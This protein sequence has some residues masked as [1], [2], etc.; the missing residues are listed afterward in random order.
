MGRHGGRAIAYIAYIHAITQIEFNR[1]FHA[2]VQSLFTSYLSNLSNPIL[3]LEP[4]S[5]YVLSGEARYDWSH[6]IAAVTEEE[7]EGEI[8]ERGKRISITFRHLNHPPSHGQKTKRVLPR[9]TA[10][11]SVD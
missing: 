8:I 1:L 2:L 5:L 3:R 9:I 10:R 11:E 6:G 7:H 4:R